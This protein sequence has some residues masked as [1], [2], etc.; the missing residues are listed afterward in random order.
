MS[1]T[2]PGRRMEGHPTGT[3]V[4]NKDE[5]VMYKASESAL[6]FSALE[7]PWHAQFYELGYLCLL[8]AS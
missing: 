1:V 8:V 4:S 5:P 2:T 7:R 6:F 3:S